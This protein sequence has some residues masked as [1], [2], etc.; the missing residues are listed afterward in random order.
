MLYFK[1]TQAGCITD[2]HGS[3]ILDNAH[4]YKTLTVEMMGYETQTIELGRKTRLKIE[5]VPV[6]V[7]LNE[8]VIKPR[9]RRYTRKDNPA[10]DLMK[11]V[12]ADKDRNIPEGRDCYQVEEYDKLTMALNNFSPDYSKMKRL[13]FAQAYVDSS[14][15]SGK[16]VLA[17]SVRESLSDVYWRK[18]PRARKTF[19][20][21][22]TTRGFDEDLDPNGGTTANLEILF[23]N[24]DIYNSNIEIFTEHF[25]G[26]VSDLG[27]LYYKYYITDTVAVSGTP[28]TEISFVPANSSGFGFTGRLYISNDGRHALRKAVLN[29]PVKIN[30]NW[31]DAFRFEQEFSPLPDSS[32]VTSKV[33]VQM[34]LSLDGGDPSVYATKTATFKNYRFSVDD[35]IFTEGDNSGVNSI[36][37]PGAENRDSTFW[38]E[39]RHIALKQS[40]SRVDEVSR[41]LWDVP[42][43]NFATRAAEVLIS[44][45]I[46]TAYPKADSKVDIG[47][48]SALVGMNAVEGFRIRLGAQTTAVLNPRLGAAGYI[49]YGFRDHK[50]KYMGKLIYSFNDKKLNFDEHPR[51]RLIFKHEYDLYSAEESEFKDNVFYSFKWGRLTTYMQYITNTSLS[52]EKEWNSGL[53]L[54]T[55]VEFKKYELGGDLRYEDAVTH[56]LAPSFNIV[57]FTLGLRYAPGEKLFNGP[58]AKRS[59][60]NNVP[61]FNLSHSFAPALLS[62]AGYGYNRTDFSFWKRTWLPL[63]GAVDTKVKAG[64]IWGKVPYPL[65]IIPASSESLMMQKET[66]HLMMPFEFVCDK[67]VSLDLTYRMKGFF[68]NHIPLVRNLKWREV[69][70][71]DAIWGGLSEK[72]NPRLN[73][74]G[75][76]AFPEMTRVLGSAPYMEVG[77]GVENIFRII[78]V[79]WFH[80]L[81]YYDTPGCQKN[82]IRAGFHLDF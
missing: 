19:I 31:V 61:I 30:L 20:K 74:E 53:T 56:R 48:V 63:T 73:P 60:A 64:Y 42:I 34:N 44:D 77:I 40:E 69:L 10:V 33:E 28:C 52:Y 8:A 70:T 36:D 82:G 14:E 12:V 58:K 50:F 47:N 7:N 18:D 72:N 23:K 38:A 3:F 25:T 41:G 2:E 75:L 81:N 27:I 24:I 5:M 57:P 62:R 16:P 17:V 46:P 79:Y 68:L 15:L 13:A 22:K 59:I 78:H 1:G 6:N 9:P 43:I 51:E 32:Y 66:F 65:L 76:M 39:N 21:A 4:G 54:N 71:F 26:P 80:R 37:L 45:F 49:A 55:M 29:T 35:K 67:Y 11:K